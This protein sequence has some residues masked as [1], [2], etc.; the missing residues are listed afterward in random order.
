MSE[1]YDEETGEVY[2]LDEYVSFANTPLKDDKGYIKAKLVKID[3]KLLISSKKRTSKKDEE[4][5]YLENYNQFELLELKEK[6]NIVYTDPGKCRLLYMLDEKKNKIFKYTG[7]QRLYETQR[8]KYQQIE[9]NM[10]KENNIIEKETELSTC[11]SKSCKFEIFKKYIK[12][13]NKINKDIEIFYLDIKFRKFIKRKFINKQRSEDKMI[14]TIKKLYTTKENGI[15]KEP[16][17][18]IGNWSISHQ[19][20]NMIS[21]PCIGLKRK[22]NKYF[23]M[24]TMDEFRTSCLNY[25]NEEKIENMVDKITKKKIHSVLILKEKEKVIGCINRD[26]NAVYNYRKIFNH[27]VETGKR[28]L[29]YD[30]TYKLE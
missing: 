12:V 24:L 18:L 2:D 6:Y 4:F 10:K 13:K 3:R 28:L 25:K 21:S 22:L 8:L 20:R 30:R 7:K 5:E 14:N 19:M 29:H 9:E 16:L 23:K 15:K 27:Y 26:R 17:I 1:N 11:N